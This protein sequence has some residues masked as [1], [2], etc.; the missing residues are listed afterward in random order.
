MKIKDL[1]VSSTFTVPLVV[2]SVSARETKSKKPYLQME[3]FDGTDKIQANYWDWRGLSIPKKN[4]IVDVTGQLTEYM[5]KPQIN[6]KGLKVN[7][8]RHLSEFT[9]SSDVNIGEVY[10]EAY[11]MVSDI[12]DDFYRSIGLSIFEELK[13][14]WITAPGASSIHH[15]YT[16]GTLIHCLSTAKIAQ[17]L[18]KEIEGANTTLATIGGMLHDVGKLFGYRINGIVCEMTDE[19]K[20]YEHS[21]IGAQFITNFAEEKK[22]LDDENNERKLQLLVHIILSHHGKREYGAAVPPASIEAHIV[23]HA[24]ML[25]ASTEQ[26]RVESNKLGNSKFTERIWTLDNVPHLTTQYVDAVMNKPAQ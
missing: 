19:G 2:I 3:L 13:G 26:I 1:N 15:A 7:A 14:L 4:T 5:G 17:A 24:D 6:V 11:E 20:L 25:D 9:P 18:S 23:H 16:A 21:F 10:M 22:L 12:D 8:E